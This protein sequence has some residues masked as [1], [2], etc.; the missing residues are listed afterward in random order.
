M[1]HKCSGCGRTAEE[2]PFHKNASRPSGL[3]NYCRDCERANQRKR[4]QQPAF[5]AKRRSYKREYRLRA[6]EALGG[7]C[8]CCGES[9]F[10][11]LQFDHVESDGAEHR[12]EI[13]KAGLTPAVVMR[14][15]ERFQVLCCNCNFAKGMWGSCP[16]LGGVS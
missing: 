5:K 10:E 7:K 16:H 11:F 14:E 1:I 12:K 2:T 9:T 6:L 13:G 8:A 4:S 15:P 3:S